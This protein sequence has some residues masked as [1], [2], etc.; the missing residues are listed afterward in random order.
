M[1]CCLLA[2]YFSRYP[3]IIKMATNK[4]NGTYDTNG[5]GSGSH[6]ATGSSP[7][8]KGSESGFGVGPAFK[9]QPAKPLP[10]TREGITKAFQQL[11][12][13]AHASES[14]FPTQTGHGTFAVAERP[15]LRQDLKA[16]RMKG[17]NA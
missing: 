11:A 5:A 10:A 8:N 1:Y 12:Q 15:G 2:I 4:T 14:P 3:N 17:T 16:L 7:V 6:T 13:W 9:E